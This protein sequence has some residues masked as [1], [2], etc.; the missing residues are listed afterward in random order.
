MSALRTRE[1]DKG[2]EIFDPVRK[3]FV[4]HT[5][6]EEVRQRTILILNNLLH[7]PVSRMAVERKLVYNGR[8]K[9]FDLMVTDETGNP[10]ILVECKAPHIP[11]NREVFDQIAVYNHIY[12]VP[13]LI[14]TNGKETHAMKVIPENG[15]YHF[16]NTIPPCNT[17]DN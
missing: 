7:Y 1:T 17:D 4:R 15:K 9:R 10:F 8:E 11:L 13:Y 16:I 3:K 5:P 2:R 12:R 6:E 14:V